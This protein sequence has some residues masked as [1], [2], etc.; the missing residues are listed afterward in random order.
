MIS[1]QSP[2]D[3]FVIQVAMDQEAAPF[4]AAAESHEHLRTQGPADFQLL[5]FDFGTAVLVRSGIGLANA[6]TATT[7]AAMLY[8]PSAVLSAG[9]AG[10]VGEDTSVGDVVVADSVRFHDSDATAFGY[11]PGQ[12]PNMPTDYP[13]DARLLTAARQWADGKGHVKFGEALSGASFIT[14]ANIGH[15][16]TTFPAALSTDMETAAIA[17]TAH[18]FGIPFAGVRAVSDLCGPKAGQDFSLSLDEAAR[19]SAQATLGLLRAFNSQRCTDIA[20][21]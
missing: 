17:Q 16:R 7:Q 4:L 9:S 3:A 11:A 14:E 10:G 6:A 13:A 20:D 1:R 15:M 12:V 18:T 21:V 5:G 8:R 19:I 2:N